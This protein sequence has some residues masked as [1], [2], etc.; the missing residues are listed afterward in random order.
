M[1]PYTQIISLGR[2]CQ[3]R[4]QLRRIRGT[5][6]AYPFDWIITPD[7][8]LRAVIAAGLAGFL[9]PQFLRRDPDGMV[10]DSRHQLRF[11]HEFPPGQLIGA[12][13]A[14]HG[15]RYA[16]LVRKWHDLMASDHRVLFVRQHGWA[17][18]IAATAALLV[19]T[20]ER[21]APALD[22][23]LLYLTEPRQHDPAQH[24]R[25]TMFRPLGQSPTGRSE[26]DDAVWD[27]LLAEVGMP[28]TPPQAGLPPRAG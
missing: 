8:G 3:P 13:L 27:A 22:F 24:A 12:G 28:P 16:N 10:C 26:G 14:Q 7:V 5:V 11:M 2:A 20:L 4:Y 9:D 19:A 18:D 17:K 21:A 15:A 23:E 6:D 25:R 1:L